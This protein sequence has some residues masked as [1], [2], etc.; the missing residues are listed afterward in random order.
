[1]H[2][3]PPGIHHFRGGVGGGGVGLLV[4]DSDNLPVPCMFP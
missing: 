2:F 4:F 3:P 1:M